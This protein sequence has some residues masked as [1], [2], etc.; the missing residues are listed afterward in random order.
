[1]RR[2]LVVLTVPALLAA[3][4]IPALA[5]T[6]T[7]KVGDNWFV[8]DSDGTPTVTVKRNDTVKWRFVGDSPHNV[9]AVSGPSRFGSETMSDGT[10][11]KKMRKRGTYTLICTVHGGDD[12]RMKLVVE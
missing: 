12:Q 9:K 8:R 6:R 2:L 11:T 5:A 10:Y 1:M 3:L 4:A 7:V